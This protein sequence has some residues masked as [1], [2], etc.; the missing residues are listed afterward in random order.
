[1]I[2]LMARAGSHQ[3]FANNLTPAF[4]CSFFEQ[5]SLQQ[6]HVPALHIAVCAQYL[7][8]VYWNRVITLLFALRLDAAVSLS[9]A[10]SRKALP[11]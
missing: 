3:E 10:R 6:S 7:I 11:G 2:C 5:L 9:F 1:M 8:R 4:I